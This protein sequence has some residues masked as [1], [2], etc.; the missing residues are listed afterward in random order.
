MGG[1]SLLNINSCK[2]AAL[3]YYVILKVALKYIFIF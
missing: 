1:N 2:D 3:C